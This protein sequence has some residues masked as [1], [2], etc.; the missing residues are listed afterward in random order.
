MHD[1]AFLCQVYS[2]LMVNNLFKLK[3]KIT[4]MLLEVSSKFTSQ[5]LQTLMIEM[6]A[7]LLLASLC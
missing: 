4:V 1:T 2:Y 3:K 5:G 6:F 7:L